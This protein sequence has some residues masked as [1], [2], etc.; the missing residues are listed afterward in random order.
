MSNTGQWS[1]Q[2]VGGIESRFDDVADEAIKAMQ[3][4]QGAMEDIR[5]IVGNPQL[6]ANLETTFSQL[7]MS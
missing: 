1:E 3:E 4:F 5:S 6:Q 2:I 7:P